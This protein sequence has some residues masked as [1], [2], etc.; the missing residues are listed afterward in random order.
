[1]TTDNDHEVLKVYCCVC[2]VRIPD[3]LDP[4]IQGLGV[5]LSDNPAMYEGGED[6]A[7]PDKFICDACVKRVLMLVGDPRRS[8]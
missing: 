6:V 2:G 3:N 8:L 4:Q 7:E 5:M 1:M